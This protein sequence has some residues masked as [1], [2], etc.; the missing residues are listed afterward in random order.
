MKQLWIIKFR[1]TTY[2]KFVHGHRNVT[3]GS[4]V[5]TDSHLKTDWLKLSLSAGML[6]F[7]YFTCNT[8][9]WQS[10][11]LHW[12]HFGLQVTPSGVHTKSKNST[13]YLCLQWILLHHTKTGPEFIYSQQNHSSVSWPLRPWYSKTVHSTSYLSMGQP[14]TVFF[15]VH[16]H[17]PSL[18]LS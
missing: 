1:V 10:F 4:S 18:C 8:C 15:I 3:R 6:P 9:L 17:V 12:D 13:I 11:W 5:L 2:H 14:H 7:A 16:P